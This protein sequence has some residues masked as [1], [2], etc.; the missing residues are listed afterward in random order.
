MGQTKTQGRAGTRVKLKE[1]AKSNVFILNDDQTTMEFVILV[2]KKVF[3]KEDI[4]AIVIMTTAH[5]TGKALVGT[6]PKNVAN[7]K[8]KKAETMA[9]VAKYPLKFQI[10]DV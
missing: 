3:D 4:E 8:V 2:L 7:A 6:Y 10:E 9:S 5:E 1:P